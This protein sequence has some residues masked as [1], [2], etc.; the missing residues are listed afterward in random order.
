MN[1]QEAVQLLREILPSSINTVPIQGCSIDSKMGGCELR[2]IMDKDIAFLDSI[3]QIL[4][5][6]GLELK[7]ADGFI[8]IFSKRK[9]PLEQLTPL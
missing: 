4:E 5:G 7:E 2:L 3:M 9:N 8:V 1:K 6:R